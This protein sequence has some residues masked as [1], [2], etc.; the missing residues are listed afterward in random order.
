VKLL[1]RF[2]VRAVVA[3]VE[4]V[5]PRMRRI[6]VTGESL[7]GLDWTPGQ[8]V[9]VRVDELRL[10]SYSVGDHVDGEYLE[11]CVLDHPGEGPGARWSRRI[12]C[13]QPVTFTRPTGRLVL[14]DAPYHLF[15]GDE[16][17]CV[18]FGAMLRA[19][20]ASASAHATIEVDGP[21]DQL[22]LSRTGQPHWIHRNAPGGIV[23]A[24]RGLDLPVEP[25]VAYVAG[26][27]LTCRAVR[28]YLTAERAWPRTAVVVKPFWTPGK[29][30]LD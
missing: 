20:P 28:R 7:R 22:S 3:D 17:A 10:R 14:R 16:T 15:V 11:L 6:R 23:G 24:L 18:A 1:D 19:L 9:R 25:G 8:H 5:T 26:E 12:R 29:R 27:A 21:G 4:R 2:L 13:G 30:G